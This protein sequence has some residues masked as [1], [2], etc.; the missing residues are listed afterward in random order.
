MT[1]S[2]SG[3]FNCA[4]MAAV[5]VKHFSLKQERQLYDFAETRKIAAAEIALLRLRI[6]AI[7]DRYLLV[8]FDMDKAQAASD[9]SRLT[10]SCAEAMRL[11]DE[12]ERLRDEKYLKLRQ[13]GLVEGEDSLYLFITEQHASS[14]L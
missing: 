4:C 5:L 6:R 7:Q 12:E 8:K 1:K 9:K 13:S 10:S 3:P 2:L 11:K 14:E